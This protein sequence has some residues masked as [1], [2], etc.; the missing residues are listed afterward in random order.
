MS[1]YQKIGLVVLSVYAYVAMLAGLKAFVVLTL[2][3]LYSQ[4]VSHLVISTEIRVIEG[5]CEIALG[6]LILAIRKPMAL[7]IG[8]RLDS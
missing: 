7:V 3:V 8:E 1:Q 4:F 2:S 6:L 5:S